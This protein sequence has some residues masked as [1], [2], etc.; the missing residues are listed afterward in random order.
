MKANDKQKKVMFAVCAT[1]LVTMI[2]PPYRRFDDGLLTRSGYDFIFNIG[3]RSVID[4]NQLMVQWL[5]ILIV[6]GIA[7]VILRSEQ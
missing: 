1:I 3:W 4:V 6:G 2:F 5:G 7:L